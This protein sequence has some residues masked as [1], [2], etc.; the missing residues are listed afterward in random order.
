MS[1]VAASRASIA[2]FRLIA[3]V[4]IGGTALLF[5]IG[6]V[7]LR[8]EVPDLVGSLLWI[9]LGVAPVFMLAV[10]LVNRRPQHVQARRLLLLGSSGA[11][12]VA[13][14]QLARLSQAD[15]S[16]DRLLWLSFAHQI[17]GTLTLIAAAALFATYPDGTVSSRWQRVVV[18]G[19]WGFLALPVIRLFASPELPVSRYLLDEP[20]YIP[21]PLAI[22]RLAWL[23]PGLALIA[24]SYL[25][26][27]AAAVVL[28]AQ[29][30]RAGPG[31]RQRMRLLVFAIGLLLPV[32]VLALVL[33]SMGVTEDSPILTAV[34]ALYLP[35]LLAIPISIVI[36]VMR[37]RL[38]EIDVIVRRSVIYGV[39]SFGIA[40]AYIGLTVIPGI[41]L[42]HRIPVELAVVLTIVAALLFQP[43]RSR[44]EAVADRRVFGAR[45]NR[46][47]LLADFGAHLER[48]VT[49]ADLLPQL[50]D[51]VRRGLDAPWVRVTLP[52]LSAVSGTV[53]PD[54]TQPDA[55]QPDFIPADPG[56][57]AAM[58]VPLDRGALHLGTIECGPK[59]GGYEPGDRELLVTLAG[60][61]AAA[62][63]NVR[64]TEELAERIEELA[65]S[66]ARIV[67][68]QDAERRR[69]ERDLH[70]G[71]QQL[72]VALI[73]NL[74]LA[75]NQLG[76]GE[77]TAD[78]AFDDL[79]RDARELL[80]DLRELAHG[81]H[82][83]VLSDGGLL[84]AVQTRAERLPLEVQITADSA[85]RTRRF[86]AD[87]EV[88]AY[89]V[90]CEALT[91]VAKHAAAANTHV[92][93]SVLGTDG[94]TVRVRDDGA[95][96]A[97]NGHLGGGLTNIRDRVEALGGRLEVIAAPGAGT[98]I[99]ADLP[100]ATTV[101]V[102]H[103]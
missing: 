55:T 50:A 86:A 83:P 15:L 19:L 68:A 41:A 94:L 62:I 59:A 85:I 79:Q 36:G 45:I 64:L 77:R 51:T 47:R 49:A 28:I 21:N 29:Y 37:Y 43:L 91:N 42:G 20:V 16:G 73:M 11:V 56:G 74:R 57:A 1:T 52:S 65:K 67:S 87:I 39:L 100:V 102:G 88:A 84:S 99:R 103:E 48:T 78:S 31:Q 81:I 9:G 66:R 70:D 34:E 61:A 93:F 23:D 69:I 13:L 24:G 89:F 63:A 96:F 44:V 32:L 3:S 5:A 82:P 4:G 40:V 46:Y 6:S 30:R 98:T 60:Q 72:V 2:G 90:V 18:R 95:G 27:I 33:R 92:T 76:R 17:A 54:A 12:G 22:P 58:S 7:L 101:A 38:Y 80:T 8:S 35:L 14:E 71:V 26:A 25:G 97:L 75:R 10:W 53:Q